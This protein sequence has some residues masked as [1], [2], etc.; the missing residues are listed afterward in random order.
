MLTCSIIERVTAVCKEEDKSVVAYFYC[1]GNYHEKKE[2][3][4]ILGSILRQILWYCCQKPENPRMII[5]LYNK[6][7]DR[8]LR[9]SELVDQI[10]HTAR[11]LTKAYIIVDGLD[12]CVMPSEICSLL[13]KCVAENINIWA[14]SRPEGE[15]RGEFSG[16]SQ[17]VLE[18]SLVQTDIETYINWRLDNERGLEKIKP[19]LKSG[20]KEKLMKESEGM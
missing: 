10:K 15:I 8:S 19:P 5:E 2:A 16:Q 13:V 17:L 11:G 20:I 9:A 3:R 18:D 6:N 4:Y 7:K 12:E 14:T 1:D